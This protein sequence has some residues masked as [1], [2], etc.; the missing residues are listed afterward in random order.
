MHTLQ[1]QKNAVTWLRII[2]PLWAVLGMF[3]LLYVPSQL[4]V[5]SD[6]ELTA[7]NIMAN[8]MLFRL[9]IAGSLITQLFSVAAVWFLYK[10]FYSTYRDATILMA[11]FAFLGIP[12]AMLSTAD[13]LMV[14]EVLD[15]PDQVVSLL[16]QSSRGTII[17]TIFWGLWL[18]PQGYMI[19]RSP[20]FPR[21]IGWFMILAGAGY[22]ISAFA[23]FLGIK[24]SLM[25]VLDYLTFGEV[26]WM[27]WVLIMGAR[28]KTLDS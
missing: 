22:T 14:L 16:K 18:L 12:I 13:Q 5:L 27:L 26:I 15:Q 2:Y 6:P 20:L 25:D 7:S 17:A 11:I 28:W 10:L 24:G 23:Y 9:G 19:I 3:S 21:I 4:I 1:E 8:E